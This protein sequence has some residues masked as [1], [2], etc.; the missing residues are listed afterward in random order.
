M[1]RYNIIACINTNLV[2][3]KDGDLMYHIS[4]DLKT[5]KTITLNSV[6]IM[7][8]KT[9]ESLP[10]GK[11]PN[12]HNIIITSDKEYKVDGAYIVHSIDECIELCETLFKGLELFV[13]GGAKIYQQFIERDIVDK[14]YITQVTDNKDGYT[15]F[16]NV[17]MDD[18]WRIFYQSQTMLDK[19]TN[20][21]YF[22]TIYKRNVNIS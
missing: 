8:R 4:D 11:L 1:K 13:I 6:V 10:K 19:K 17:L 16:P 12:R 9:Y 15:Y 5:F 7:G 3:G 14:M 22:F 21:K 20:L 2:L 18:K